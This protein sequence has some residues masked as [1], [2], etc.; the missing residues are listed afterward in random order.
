MSDDSKSNDTAETPP[1]APKPAVTAKKGPDIWDQSGDWIIAHGALPALAVITIAVFIIHFGVFRGESAGDDLSFHFAESARIADCLRHFDFDLW[2]PSANAGYASAYYYQVLPQLASALPAAIFGHHLFWFQLSIVLPLILAPAAAYRGMRLLGATPWQ[3]ALAAFCIAF[4]NGASRWGGG[5]AGTFQVGLYTQTWALAAFPLALGHAGRWMEHGKGLAP[6][7]AWGAFVFMCHPFAGVT[8]ALTVF[9]AW[10]TQQ[11]WLLIELGLAIVL[12]DRNFPYAKALSERWNKPIAFDVM[13]RELIRGAILGVLLLI[14]WA[15]IWL[16]LV[17]DRSG[18]GGFPHRVGDE[19]GPGFAALWQWTHKGEILDYLPPTIGFRFPVL[20]YAVPLCI[21]FARGP[22]FRWLW[23]GAV[24]FFLMLGFGPHMGKIGDDIFPPVRALG[25]MQALLAMGVGAGAIII[26]SKLWE[27]AGRWPHQA[28]GIRTGLA[29]VAAGLVVLVALPGG[30]ALASRIRVLGDYKNSHREDLLSISHQL[31]KLPPGRKQVGPGAEN[32]WWNLLSYA[33]DRVPSLLQMGGGGLQA[34]PNYD[35]LWTN[36]DHV[37]NA[38]IYDAPY[39]VFDKA[40]GQHMPL[41]ETVGGTASYEIRKLPSP[42]LVSPVQVTGVLPPGYS[43]TG[44]GHKAALEWIKS[45]A[46]MRDEVL[47]Y[48][49]SGGPGP[50]PKGR[51]LRSWYQDSPGSQADIVAEVEADAPTTYV[52]RESWHP[53][54]HAYIDGNEVPVR[55]VT[56]DFPAVD[57]PVGKH[58]I[59]MRF[60]RPWWLL[61]SWLLWP[62]IA[63]AAWL[64]TRRLERRRAAAT[65]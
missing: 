56:P 55:R 34:S 51:T 3:A 35:F 15:P 42:G 20:T 16:P 43:N 1:E 53:R 38:W 6:A 49:G 54:W 64:V 17:F 33:Y 13:L 9:M 25:A 32:H 62:G 60:E 30:R 8:L 36:R 5:N 41:G 11:I 27:L 52:V 2:N 4:T 19:V 57:V 24:V 10:L 50:A 22:M 44:A 46:P 65:T 26:G 47:A 23:P 7:V 18:F 48:A 58:T 61:G 39:V 31:A 59:E 28:Y 45:D 37:K 29:A 14:T 40:R 63:I 21:L 12:R